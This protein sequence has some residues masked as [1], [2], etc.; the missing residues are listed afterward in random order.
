M[1]H[2]FKYRRPVRPSEKTGLCGI[3]RLPLALVLVLTLSHAAKAQ[4]QPQQ[5]DIVSI[6]G[7][8]L[9][10][11]EGRLVAGSRGMPIQGVQ[12]VLVGLKGAPVAS[13]I[14]DSEGTFAFYQLRE[15]N[16]TITFTAPGAGQQSLPVEVSGGPIRGL[17]IN[18]ADYEVR[19]HLDADAPPVPVWAL[20]IPEKARKLNNEGLKALQK[21]D[22]KRSVEAL[23]K[24]VGVYSEYASARAT[25][26]TAYLL[27]RRQTDAVAAFVKALEID[28][29]LPEACLGLG[30]I[31]T[32]QKRYGEAETLLLRAQTL[33][34][35][36]WRVHLQLGEN[37]FQWGQYAKAETSLRRAHELHPQFPRTHVLLMNAL[38]LQEK[39]A[40]AL[41]EMNEFL[42]LFPNDA[43]AP[44]V[45]AKRDALRNHLGAVSPSLPRP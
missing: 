13:C 1:K 16:Y 21:K 23:E 14:T 12:M 28:D 22:L 3:C 42:E 36:D 43:F 6:G 15:G 27:Q 34:S 33:K 18:L 25:L 11:V 44:G 37:Y 24:A 2:L 38:V 4:L 30:S 7:I 19:K 9:Y 41:E 20:R 35:D 26:G 5:P 31:Y 32:T 10:T 45:R 40:D 29:N 39:Y 8:R 17:Q